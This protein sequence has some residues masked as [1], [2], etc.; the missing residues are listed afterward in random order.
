MLS[1]LRSVVDCLTLYVVSKRIRNEH[2][3]CECLIII[4]GES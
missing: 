2:L 4:G 1:A 3:L